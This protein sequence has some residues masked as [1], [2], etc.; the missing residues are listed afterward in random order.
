MPE[1]TTLLQQILEI[2][3][4]MRTAALESDWEF[5]QQSEV[6]RRP[7]IERCFPL[8]DGEVNSELA[9]A[10]IREIIELDLSIKSL[11]LFAHDELAQSLGKLKLGRQAVSAYASVKRGS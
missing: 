2:T 4:E 11:A 8:Q 7:L 9:A 10:S 6:R 1:S 5:V 3:R